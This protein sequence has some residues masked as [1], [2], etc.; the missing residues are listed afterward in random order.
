MSRFHLEDAI[1]DFHASTFG[2]M[3]WGTWASTRMDLDYGH[4][5]D[6]VVPA[7]ATSSAILEALR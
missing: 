4:A 1:L 2:S 6:A 7:V 5:E 3:D